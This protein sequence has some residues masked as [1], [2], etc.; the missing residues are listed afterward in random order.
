MLYYKKLTSETIVNIFGDVTR[1]NALHAGQFLCFLLA[2]V[3][4]EIARL[5]IS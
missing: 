4:R 1:Y 2:I 3:S 5:D